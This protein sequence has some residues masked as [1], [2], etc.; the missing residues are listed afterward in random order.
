MA[1]IL[2]GRHAP[3]I[4]GER[5]LHENMEEVPLLCPGCIQDSGSGGYS[6][7]NSLPQYSYMSRCHRLS[8]I[9]LGTSPGV[10]LGGE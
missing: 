4:G 9:T 10:V 1:C 2:A 5:L 8:E 3:Y 6:E 7:P